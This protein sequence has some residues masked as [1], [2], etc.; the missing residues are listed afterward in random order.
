MN[1]WKGVLWIIAYPFVGIYLLIQLLFAKLMSNKYKKDPETIN[2]DERYKRVMSII[3]PLLFLKNIEVKI[4]DKEN[5]VIKNLLYIGNHKSNGDPIFLLKAIYKLASL[6][7]TFVA[8]K[9]LEKS[10]L[11]PIFNL[12]DVIFIDRN[13]L[14]QIA[15]TIASQEKILKED[16][17][18]LVIFPEGTRVFNDSFNEFKAGALTPAYNTAASIMPFVIVNSAGSFDSKD[19]NNNRFKRNYFIQKQVTV[20]FLKPINYFEYVNISKESL[21]KRIQ[22]NI[23]EK[24]VEINK[25][26]YNK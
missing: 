2:A 21:M 4:E 10:F 17:R 15:S 20:S 3:N 6:N 8:K 18:G 13:N 9:E 16:N 25:K 23:Y 5:L 12:L 19:E 14:R 11:A 1:F 24:Y 7:I 26:T 22:A